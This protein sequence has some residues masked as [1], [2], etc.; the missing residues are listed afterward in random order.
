MIGALEAFVNGLSL[1]F[2]YTLLSLGFVII[3]RSTRVFNFAHGSIMLFGIYVVA[4]LVPA[5][6]F[7]PAFLMGCVVVVVLA[8][9]I[10]RLLIAPLR[11]RG[12][13]HDAALIMTLGVD[14]ILLT[15]LTR[16][17]GPRVLDSG[18][19]WGNEIVMFGEL[20]LPLARLVAIIACVIILGALFAAMKFT[21]W[22]IAS[23]AAAE[24]GE[25]AA[26]MGINLDRVGTIAWA[27]AGVLALIA[28]I[29]LTSLPSAGITP[30]V[31]LV[32]LNAFPA[33]VV[34][35][36]DSVGGALVGGLIIGVTESF[37]TS[38][39]PQLQ[40]LGAGFGT[41]VPWVVM[42]I[43]LLVRPTGLFGTKEI[44]RV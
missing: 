37:A 32:A 20:S 39:G 44:S 29:F 9:A 35:G 16:L 21:G 4:R 6:G 30:G 17:I 12:A 42:L 18:G 28:G 14:L 38:Y 10:E 26:L 11:R 13:S 24:D 27:L 22:G 33:A 23:R 1:G 2:I 40:F 31:A 8:V 41:I 3:Y 15:E 34:G 25:A 5:W 7:V 43:V 36:L 19:P